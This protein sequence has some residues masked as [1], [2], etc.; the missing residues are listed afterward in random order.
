VE[1][2]MNNVFQ[3]E[4]EEIYN[5]RLKKQ[6]IEKIKEALLAGSLREADIL[7]KYSLLTSKEEYEAIKREFT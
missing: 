6:E 3:K 5:E 7:F 4:I 2:K 1:F